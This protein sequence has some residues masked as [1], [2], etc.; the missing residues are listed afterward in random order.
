VGPFSKIPKATISFILSV[1]LRE[2]TRLSVDGFYLNFIFEN[3]S[4][5]CWENSSL[6][7]I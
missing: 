2:T 1:R 7:K 5:I 6:I 3:F 4:K